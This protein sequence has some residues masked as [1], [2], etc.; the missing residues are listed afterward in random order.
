M[1]VLCTIEPGSR[2]SKIKVG[3]GVLE[4]QLFNLAEKSYWSADRLALLPIYIRNC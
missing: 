4:R 1:K 3:H 2:K